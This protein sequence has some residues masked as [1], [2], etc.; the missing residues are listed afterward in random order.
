VSTKGTARHR[1]FDLG[2][3]IHALSFGDDPP[4]TVLV[5]GVGS[6]AWSW[7]PFVEALGA[8]ERAIAVDMRGHGDSQWAADGD[9]STEAHAADMAGVL[10]AVGARDVTLVGASWGGLVGLLL[11][12]RRPDLV[13]RLVM[14]DLAP[15]STKDPDDVPPRP[16]SFE[17]HGE[18]VAAEQGRNPRARP[19]TVEL[20]ATHGTRPA[21]GGR[22]VPK[23]DPL[24]L[25]RWPFRAEDHWEALR[26]LACPLL[27]VKAS[28]SPVLPADDAERM[29]AE[30]KDA[31]LELIGDTGHVVHLDD[32]QGLAAMVRAF[33]GRG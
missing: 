28:D 18:V 4:S 33:A 8:G 3:R 15:S 13:R 27:V 29:V 10:E 31:R 16:A 22:L 30:A 25:R 5:H 7:L 21:E 24:F 9:Y 12:A 11:A 2:L 26:S 6:H 23:H 19:Q 20:L 32:P 1:W 17:R 14:V